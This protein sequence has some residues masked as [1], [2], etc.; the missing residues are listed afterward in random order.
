MDLNG[1]DNFKPSPRNCRT[2]VSSRAVPLADFLFMRA[3]HFASVPMIV[4]LV[5]W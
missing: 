5:I 2:S 4:N 1:I 3:A